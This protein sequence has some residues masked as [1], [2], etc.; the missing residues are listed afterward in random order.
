MH[1]SSKKLE[2]N[3]ISKIRSAADLKITKSK[4][5]SALQMSFNSKR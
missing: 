3:A 5:K 2:E 4:K 1:A